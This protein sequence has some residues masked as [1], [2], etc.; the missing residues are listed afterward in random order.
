MADTTTNQTPNNAFVNADYASIE[1]ALFSLDFSKFKRAV[2]QQFKRMQEKG[3][4]SGLFVAGVEGDDLWNTYLSSFP[5]GT[6]LVYRKRTEHDCSGCR[7]FVKKVGRL[8]AIIDGKPETIWDIK[9]DVDLAYKVVA[10]ALATKVR[11]SVIDNGF[12]TPETVAGVD[13]S[14]ENIV[15]DVKAWEHFFIKIPT[16]YVAKTDLIGTKLSAQRATHDVMF[17]SLTEI[18][19]D[20]VAT[21]QELIGQNSLY[22][23]EENKFAVD[24]FAKLQKD[25]LKIPAGDATARD[26][27]VWSEVNTI[28][29]SVSRIRNTAIGTLL[30]SLSEGKEIEDAVRAFEAMVAPANY[31]RPTALVTKAQVEK[32]K[33]T[34]QDLGLTS[35]LQRRFAVLKDIT[36]NNII[37]AD[38]NAKKALGGGDVFDELVTSA[39]KV[40]SKSFDKVEEI[41]IEKFLSD[42]LPKATS[43]EIFV[44][45]RHTPNLVSLI[46]PEDPAAGRLFKWDNQFSWS[47]NGEMADAIKERVKAAGGSVVG[48]LC[49][50]L[51]W[52]YT[53]DLDF[54][55]MEP[56]G[57]HI[58]YGQY[59]RSKSPNGGVLDLDANG[60]DG[61]RDD[62]AE[63]IYY[64]DKRFMRDGIYTL[65]VNN[66]NRRS[67]GKGFVVEVEFG[68]QI[69]RIEY[70]KALRSKDTVEVARIQLKNGEFT[71]LESLPSTQTS[72]EVWGLKTQTFHRANVVMMSPNHWDGVGIGNK[73]YFFMVDGCQNDGTARG[74]FNEFLKEELN[75]HRKVLEMVGG[76][77]KVREVDGGAGVGGGDGEQLSGLGF[78]STAR[79]T[80]VCRVKG[81]FTRVVKIVF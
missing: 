54:H 11:A 48:D 78:S 14:F 73:H 40:G 64:A 31:K 38:R 65:N 79:N 37:F 16:Q 68:G 49:C 75:Q 67:D 74:F 56:G 58:F 77:M 44:E 62:P 9:G 45:N 72:K 66:Y 20:A 36:V 21:V 5:E 47:Y 43:V 30:V 53:D 23:G 70:D 26:I 34:I 10:D 80:L 50:R 63:N 24:A 61:F 1:R 18:T 81:S 12:L 8:V 71:I 6:N 4:G 41:G 35:A 76:K 2:A 29:V 25:F 3:S 57:H 39:T 33:Q 51:A 52:D 46:A 69:H 22:R 13:K 55:C 60:A 42:V 27:F 17:R 32:A 59:R 19:P 7:S 28:P 15:N